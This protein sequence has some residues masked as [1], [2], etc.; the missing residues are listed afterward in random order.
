MTGLLETLGL[1]LADFREVGDETGADAGTRLIL[2]STPG[3]G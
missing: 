3:V 1:S 2:Q